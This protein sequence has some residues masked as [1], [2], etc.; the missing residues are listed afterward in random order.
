MIVRTRLDVEFITQKL[1]TSRDMR[2]QDI[3][4]T[5]DICTSH[6]TSLCCSCSS[7]HSFF[8]LFI[9]S[10][11]LFLMLVLWFDVTIVVH[12]SVL[13]WR[14]SHSFSSSLPRKQLLSS[15]LAAYI[16]SSSYAIKHSTVI[17]TLCTVCVLVF[18]LE[19]PSSLFTFPII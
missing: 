16:P 6:M 3:S 10:F 18:H 2:L 19:I 5:R 14:P 7:F 13:W 15:F 12:L 4:D 8:P 11:P 9:C 17:L 1:H